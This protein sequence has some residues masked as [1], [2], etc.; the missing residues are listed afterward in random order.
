MTAPNTPT[1]HYAKVGLC[2][3]FLSA[4]DAAAYEA[5]YLDDWPGEPPEAMHTPRS[6]GYWDRDRE[7][8][9]RFEARLEAARER[10]RY[11]D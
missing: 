8:E 5:G 9:A 4:A 7:M 10:V 11:G 6:Q 1:I 3:P 2:R